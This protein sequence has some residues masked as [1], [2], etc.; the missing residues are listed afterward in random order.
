MPNKKINQLDVKVAV[1]TDLMLVGDPSTGT[2]FKSTVATLPLVPY[3]GATGAVS[4]GLFGLTAGTLTLQPQALNSDT[5]KITQQMA[6]ND[7]WSIYGFATVADYGDLYFEL[8]DNAAFADGQRFRFRYGN[9]SSGTPKDILLMDYN[10]ATIDGALTVVN[11][12]SADQVL[13]DQTPTGTAGVGVMRWNDSDGTLDFGL[14]G[15]N[16]TLQLGQEQVQRVVNK[17]G[18]NL[19]EANYQV[20]KVTDAQGQRL[21]V[22]LAQGNNDA[23]STDTIG[24]VTETI[25]NNQEGF[26]TTSGIIRGINTT[27]SLQSETWVDGDVL[28]LSPTVAGRITN[29]KPTA[30]SHTVTL[31]YVVYAHA[32]NGKIFVKCDNGYEIGELHD[33]YVPTPSNNDGIF[34]NSTNLRYENNSIVGVL[35]YTPVPYTGA[36]GAVNLGAYDLTVNG[37]TVGLGAASIASN[38]VFG[39][40]AGTAFTTAQSS[41]AIGQTALRNHQTGNWNTAIGNGSMSQDVNGIA[42]T[43]LGVSTL[44]ALTSNSNIGNTSIGYNG[45]S[46]LTNGDYNTYL[47]YSLGTGGILTTGSFN[48]ILG[49]QV[50][51]GVASLSNNIIIADGQG[52]IRFRDDATSTILSR[53]AGTGTRMVVTDAN[54]ALSTQSIPSGGGGMAIGGAITSATA[55]SVLFAGASG[56]LAQ[57][58]ALFYWDDTNARLAIGRNTATGKLDIQGVATT[59]GGQLGSELTTTGSGTN[60]SGTSFA[61]GYTHTAGST[62]ALTTTLA[63]VVG[64]SYQLSWT[65]TG[66]TVGNLQI[67]YGG[68]VSGNVFTNNTITTRATATTNFSITP[69]TDFN[70]TI[71]LSIK[72]I[73]AGTSTIILRNS[74]GAITNEIRGGTSNTN[75]FIGAES[76]A[77]TT[78]G[79]NNTAIGYQSLQNNLQGNYNMAIG[80]RTLQNNTIGIS[81]VAIGSQTLIANISGSSNTSI[82]DGVMKLNTSGS[83]N[84]AIGSGAMNATTTGN[85]NTSVGQSSLAGNTTAVNNVAIG[86]ETLMYATGNSNTAIGL[87][88]GSKISGGVTNNSACSNSLFVG[89]E[90]RPLA[91]NQTNQIVIGFQTTGLGSNTTVIGNSSTTDAAIYGRL[92]VNYSAPVIGT[93]A[94]DVNGTA[95]V[96]SNLTTAQY[97][98][99]ALNTAPATA[100]ST[101][102]L[103]EIRIDA[104]Y[105]YVCTATNTWVRSALTTW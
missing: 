12:V 102:T 39:N 76:G 2:S 101:G 13:F 73:T 87:R 72:Q 47:G 91:D 94:L 79:L 83:G 32:N 35:G 69:T 8:Q 60:W 88:A 51:V 96:V 77:L 44:A 97:R 26:I 78:I 31:G 7:Y 82:G 61:T 43:A 89:N 14:K 3:T 34:W 59:D 64:N 20:V 63:A 65:I 74:S 98:L 99:S 105:I 100:S 85:N 67:L 70:G 46:R 23:N 49:A 90:T 66:R 104:S 48:T 40:L 71:V 10:T 42:N 92:L 11:T 37:V 93:Y 15:G 103:G 62:D 75:M 55:G 17:S 33:V 1:A 28:Y 16:V 24:I 22:D 38:T 80:Y 27:G 29:I 25:N 30:P 4:L 50:N 6:T 18:V 81:N 95:R 86:W 36:T 41:T 58:N 9:A 52:N 5:Y 54:G 45:L 56:V 84:T 57:N 53:L 19:L 21:A 68:Y